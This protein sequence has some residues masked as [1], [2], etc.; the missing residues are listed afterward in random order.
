MDHNFEVQYFGFISNLAKKLLNFLLI[1]KYHIFITLN[2]SELHISCIIIKL[3][4]SRYWA[5]SGS[6]ESRR[7]VPICTEQCYFN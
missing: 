4:F 1:N 3:Y 5:L 2:S 6:D 7:R